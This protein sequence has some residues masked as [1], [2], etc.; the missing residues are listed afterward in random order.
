MGRFV[1]NLRMS[2]ADYYALTLDER[3]AIVEQWNQAN[4]RG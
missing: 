3:E 2:P 1:V 4:R